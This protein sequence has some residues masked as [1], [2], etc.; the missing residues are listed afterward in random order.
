LLFRFFG[1]TGRRRGD[2]GRARGAGTNKS[3]SFFQPINQHKTVSYYFNDLH[4]KELPPATRAKFQKVWDQ[5]VKKYPI[6]AQNLKKLYETV[7]VIGVSGESFCVFL[8]F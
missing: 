3:L 6:D 5:G 8:S 4:Q 7:D 2:D 1:F